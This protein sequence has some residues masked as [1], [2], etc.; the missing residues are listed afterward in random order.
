L[1]DGVYMNKTKKRKISQLIS[2]SL[3]VLFLF[4]TSFIVTHAN[5]LN[6]FVHVI[7]N[8]EQR[9]FLDNSF[10]SPLLNQKGSMIYVGGS[11]PGNF[12]LIQSAIDYA[13]SGDTIFVYNGIYYETIEIDKKI[14]LIGEDK[15]LTIIDGGGSGSTVTI[16][17]SDVSF[18][19][20]TVQNGSYHGIDLQNAYNTIIQNNIIR[21]NMESGILGFSCIG[22]D[23]ID[24]SI[25]NNKNGINLQSYSRYCQI[26]NNTVSNHTNVGI[27]IKNSYEAVIKN[28]LVNN[29][30]NG[31]YFLNTNHSQ[32]TSNDVINNANYGIEIKQST[33]NK[34]RYNQI[35]FNKYGV[36]LWDGSSTN[37]IKGNTVITSEN[38]HPIAVDVSVS[39]PMN[40][41]IHINVTKNDFDRDGTINHSSVSLQTPPNNGNLYDMNNGIIVYEPHSGFNGSDT[42]S[43]LVLDNQHLPSNVAM[44]TINVIPD[45]L[46]ETPDQ[47]QTI[48]NKSIDIYLDRQV[49]QSFLSQAKTI[50][51]VELYLKT[52]GN[53]PE[54]LL[55]TIHKA[56]STGEVVFSSSLN[57]SMINSS[58]EWVSF[59]GADFIIDSSYPYFIVAQSM[60]GNISNC[61]QWGYSNTSQYPQGM[62]HFSADN[63]TTWADYNTSD[64]CFK[65][66]RIPGIAPVSANNTYKTAI[67][68]TLSIPPPGFLSNDHDYDEEP[69]QLTAILLNNVSYGFLSL[70]SDGSFTY[71]PDFDF[72]G[73]DEFTYIASDGEQHSSVTTVHITVTDNPRYCISIPFSEQASTNNYIYH[74]NFISGIYSPL[75]RDEHNNYWDGSP[76]GLIGGNHWSDFNEYS[77]GAIDITSNAIFDQVY[78]ISG[79]DNLDC[80]PLSLLWTSYDPIADFSWAQL[81]PATDFLIDFTDQSLDFGYGTI[82]NWT[83]DLGDGNL[84]YERSFK[85]HYGSLGVY[86]VSLT[87]IDDDGL[88]DFIIKP[89]T[90][91]D[92][93]PVADFRWTPL[94]PTLLDVIQFTDLSTD[95]DGLIVNWTWDFGDGNTSYEQ[96]PNHH[97]AAYGEY[98]V[99]LTIID[100][101]SAQNTTTKTVIVSNVGL[102]AMF[103]HT[104][105][106]PSV[107]E[108]I[109]FIDESFDG[110]GTIINWSWD[111]GDGN[112]SFDQYPSHQFSSAGY[113]MVCLTVGNDTGG[114]DNCCKEVMVTTGDLILDVNQTEFDR[115]FRLMPGWDGYQEFVPSFPVLST[116]ELYMTKSGSPTGDVTVQIR[117]DDA[118][119]ALLF[120]G[121]ISPDDVI[122]SFPSYE[123]VSIDTSGIPVTPGETYVIILLS[124]DDGAGTH[125]NLQWAWSDSYPAGSDGPY[126]DGWF[127][128]RKDFSPSWSFVRDWDFTFKTFG[129]V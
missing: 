87:I 9:S 66:Y 22:C 74:N 41:G 18:Q 102:I 37:V 80:Y 125:H 93:L 59:D 39:T 23:L 3:C 68:T 99:S 45:D 36:R 78:D 106:Y 8:N 29:N 17:N 107:N 96:H 2:I 86:N 21:S 100:N 129:L 16:D 127:F 101:A 49:A 82:V 81:P 89:V 75:A 28:S 15:S 46:G 13:T 6:S 123:W 58:I 72:E 57:E 44:V 69:E 103:S 1:L 19:S 47:M 91:S 88:T 48:H 105:L 115:G 126:E 4:S 111:F 120:D 70:H 56:N 64:S 35:S 63:G 110:Y 98:D 32:V 118:S 31:I 24:N 121:V 42:F 108:T 34:I 10:F 119:G 77:E 14:S 84:S 53:P 79:G 94:D 71:T 67:G 55:V 76:L 27:F 62:L 124:P 11:G 7:G 109:D 116:V 65:T 114:T 112:T 95:V 54:P 50:T 61:Y 26:V 43:Y 92:S 12:S 52:V 83:W 128:F 38:T 51:R 97:Y 20:F 117:E 60:G 90:V 73:I 25:F 33:A 5:S 113:Y 85:H 122:A 104:P 30:N 40:T